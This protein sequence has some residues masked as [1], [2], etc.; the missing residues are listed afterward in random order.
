MACVVGLGA[1]G[2]GE[3]LRREE[4]GVAVEGVGADRARSP[5]GQGEGYWAVLGRGPVFRLTC[6]PLH[7]TLT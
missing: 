1:M 4:G 6:G 3:L 7:Y 2:R 5:L